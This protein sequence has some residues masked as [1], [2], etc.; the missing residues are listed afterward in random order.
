[1]GWDNRKIFGGNI[2]LIK[3]FYNWDLHFGSEKVDFIETNMRLGCRLEEKYIYRPIWKMSDAPNPRDA[4]ITS[5]CKDTLTNHKARERWEGTLLEMSTM[6]Q[7]NGESFVWTDREVE[8][9]LNMRL[10]YEV[11]KTQEN[12]M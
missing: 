9:P 2:T 1:M 5:K 8:S 10:E 12:A 6:V 7:P 3:V 11:N 4:T